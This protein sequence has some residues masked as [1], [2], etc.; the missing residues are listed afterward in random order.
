MKQQPASDPDFVL[1]LS[2]GLSLIEAFHGEREGLTVSA[3]AGKT[4]LSRAAV[5]RL[6]ITLESLGYAERTGS[7]FRLTSRILRLGFSFVTS[8]A[9]A[10]LAL[11]LLA[12]VSER[13][14][15][16][17]S[18]SLLDGDHIVYVA[19]SAPRRVMT[20]D[21]GVGSRLPAYCTSMGRVLL[22]ALPPEEL[23][24]YL[25][26]VR[27]HKHTP[28]T[29]VDRERL[30]RLL[31]K[32]RTSGYALVDEELEVGLRSIAVPVTSRSGRV[33]AAMNSGVPAARVS[34]A[35]LMERIL[36]VLSDHARLLGQL[37]A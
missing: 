29:V 19:R 21:L 25:G 28:K 20:I 11:P 31:K 12:Q 10:E 32:V 27:L 17:S 15:E 37:L 26:N 2:R 36:P 8:N 22:A 4:G 3:A 9:I 13:I 1:S 18:V 14:H 34:A 23:T 7:L 33:V 30:G 5:R 24:R 6:L 16:S 35:Q